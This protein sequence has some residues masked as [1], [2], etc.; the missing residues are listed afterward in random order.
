MKVDLELRSKTL[1]SE[2]CKKLI[3]KGIDNIPNIFKFGASKIKNKNVERAL[4]SEIA[5][6]V[7]EEEQN[8]GKNKCVSLF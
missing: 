2:V 4:K 5:D 7:V 3:N 6:M 1:G 8:R